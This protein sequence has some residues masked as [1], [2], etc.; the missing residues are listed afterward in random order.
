M[1]EFSI[2]LPDR[3]D[4]RRFLGQARARMEAIDTDEWKASAL[5]AAADVRGRIS[6]T[7]VP[8]AKLV[9]AHQLVRDTRGRLE[10]AYAIL[11]QQHEATASGLEGLGHAELRAYDGPLRQ[12]V[13]AF[14]KLKHVTVSDLELTDLPPV[15]AAFDTNIDDID[16]R[17][18]D[19]LKSLVAGGTAGAA[20]GMVTMAAVGTFATASTG[21]AIGTLSGAAAT[22]A[23]LAWLGGGSLVAGGGGIAAGTLVLGGLVAA[24]VLA[25]GGLVVHH[26]GRAALT[27]AQADALEADIA[28]EQMELAQT[29][30]RG[31]E[32]RAAQTC[33]V[34]EPLAELL[35]QR[36]A[37]L[38]RLASRNADYAT[39][40]ETDRSVVM[41]AATIAKT[42]RTLIDVPIITEDGKPTRE[43]RRV[44]EA[45]QELLTEVLADG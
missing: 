39:Y 35:G 5:A 16:F 38:A 3:S 21:T 41:A 15:I 42:V 11:E 23:T 20:S 44:V 25:V 22:N 43:S 1:R 13:D 31:I 18:V 36:A 19:A 7:E 45:S 24:P 28:I 27:R 4:S 26:K 34:L 9:V 10:G 32:L 37:V 29:V 12:F 8:K 17:G 30:A 40:D 14:A 33:E 6:E 2:K